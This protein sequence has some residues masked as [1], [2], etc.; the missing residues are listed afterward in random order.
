MTA[1][2][3]AGRIASAVLVV[4]VLSLVVGHLLGTPILLGYVSSNSMEPTID[5]GDAFVSIPQPLAGDIEEG[6]V[7]VYEARELDGGGLTTHRVVEVRDD[8]YVT[9]GDNNPFT[10]QDG[11]EPIVTDEQVKA[12]VL[13][14]G[15]HVVTIPFL[16]TLVEGIGSVASGVRTT[17]AETFGLGAA[18]SPQ[19][20]GFLLVGSGLALVVLA[21]LGGGRGTRV[22]DRRTDRENVIK[23]WSAIGAV[24]VLVV[25]LATAAMVLP[26]GVQEF[27]IES[28]EDP[29]DDPLSVE[30]GESA[31]I[32]YE[33]NN[34]GLVPT[35]VI[36]EPRTNDVSVQPD[37]VT[38][39]GRSTKTATA[40]IQAPESEGIH[41]RHAAEHRYLLV[42]PPGMLEAA[43]DVH[44]LAALVLV[45]L[46]IAGLVVLAG[47]ALLGTN[48]IRVRAGSGD[49]PLTVR[50]RRALFRW[51]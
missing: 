6:D 1:R 29:S 28:S 38:V 37:R 23:L 18:T 34:A 3:W 19:G 8:G 30:P 39:G 33:A 42:L 46:V 26:G 35:V 51:F 32:E 11:P 22:T 14:V 9:K 25:L 10:D 49:R 31:T 13:Q 15:G 44:P 41:Y 7:I 36:M 43:H 2:E 45:D 5:E 50:L 17:L 21:A 20:F 48:D 4:V 16:G 27:G 47:V 40:T 24:A 12:E